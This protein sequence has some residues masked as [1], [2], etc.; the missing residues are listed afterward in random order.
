MHV[1]GEWWLLIAAYIFCPMVEFSWKSRS[2]ST[3][4]LLAVMHQVM[5]PTTWEKGAGVDVLKE[6]GAV[7]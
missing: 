3:S 1:C 7:D 2:A 6:L 4:T 5:P